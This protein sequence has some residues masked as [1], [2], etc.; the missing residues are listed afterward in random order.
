MTTDYDDR[1]GD[2]P[3]PQPVQKNFRLG[4][5]TFLGLT[6]LSAGALIFGRKV[7]N[8]FSFTP[9]TASADGFTIYTVTGGYPSFQADSYRLRIDGMVKNPITMTIDD[10]LRH[11]AVTETRFYQCV[12]GWT[13][14]N[15][16]NW[17]P[18]IQI[19]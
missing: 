19:G 2:R 7:G 9:G 3:V 5:A 6:A 1:I 4:R 10:I 12:T 14:P 16:R 8:P 11:P 18:T 15:T 13:V 17:A